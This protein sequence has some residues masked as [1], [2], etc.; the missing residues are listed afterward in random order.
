MFVPYM[1]VFL[2][3]SWELYKEGKQIKFLRQA[4]SLLGEIVPLD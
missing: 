3:D 4:V 1:D 2:V